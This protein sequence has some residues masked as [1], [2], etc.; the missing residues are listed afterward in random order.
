MQLSD[1]CTLMYH[2]ESHVVV[3]QS[4]EVRYIIHNSSVGKKAFL[5]TFRPYSKLKKLFGQFIKIC[6]IGSLKFIKGF[7]TATVRLNED[8]L[9]YLA[10]LD[11][12]SE[13][14]NILIGTYD[15][16]QKII[17]QILCNGS[18]YYLKVGDSSSLTLML[19]EIGFLKEG[20][21]FTNFDVP[22]YVS[23]KTS[24]NQN[25]LVTEHFEGKKQQS[26]FDKKIFKCW[27]EIC[28]LYEFKEEK[29]IR[30][31]FS[32]GDFTPWNIILRDG[33]PL[34]YDWEYCGYRF[35][36]FDIIHYNFQ[37][38]RLINGNSTSEALEMA[39][40]K[41]KNIDIYLSQMSKEQLKKLYIEEMGKRKLNL[42]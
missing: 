11:I 10:T 28:N 42:K 4:G 2:K 13:I 24:K 29:G 27:E 12:E 22:K 25:I 41:V 36:G 20:L 32:H 17:I 7:S 35:Y 16:F 3:T 8:I 1:I 40:D 15:E 30:M 38:E 33:K 31:A 37:V 23:S 18:I 34:I 39:I 14:F 26:I 6:S 19:S 5:R 21:S 9:K